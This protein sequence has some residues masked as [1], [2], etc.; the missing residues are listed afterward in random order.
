MLKVIYLDGT[1]Q[2]SQLLVKKLEAGQ[3]ASTLQAQTSYNF[4]RIQP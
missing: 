2:Q 4:S 3:Q 1:N